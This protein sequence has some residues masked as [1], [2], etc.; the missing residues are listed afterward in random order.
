VHELHDYF[1]CGTQLQEMY[2]THALLS[3]ANWDDLAE[4]ANWSRQNAATLVDTH[5]I[6]GDPA[7]L[8][9]YGWAAWSTEKG[10]ITLRNPSAQSKSISLDVGQTFEL[11]PGSPLRFSAHSPWKRDQKAKSVSL[12]AGVAHAF[13][14]RPFEV[15]NLEAIPAP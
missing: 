5:W 10:I 14:L 15:L 1:G 12:V 6:G 2:I 11:P 7:K 13:R 9:V 4:A 3:D 8:E